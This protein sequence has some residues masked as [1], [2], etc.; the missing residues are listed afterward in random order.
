MKKILIIGALLMG[1][2]VQPIQEN[3]KI[4]ATKG[5]GLMAGVAALAVFPILG[6]TIFCHEMGHAAAFKWCYGIDSHIYIGGDDESKQPILY[7][8][9]WMTIYKS[10]WDG[11]MCCADK[12]PQNK[13][14]IKEF[15]VGAAGGLC[16]AASGLAIALATKYCAAE[17]NANNSSITGCIAGG[18]GA[19]CVGSIANDLAQWYPFSK[20]CDGEL[21]KQQLSPSLQKYYEPAAIATG[22][23]LT[24]L[25]C[26]CVTR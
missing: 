19:A 14:P 24:A 16:G 2:T 26:Y 4:D 12:V 11:G 22:A 3:M 10:F 13:T 17:C 6:I 5:L 15:I 25:S 9:N 1:F 20:A 7:K 23:I 18:I 21:M 8:N